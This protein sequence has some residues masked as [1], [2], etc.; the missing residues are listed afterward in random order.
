MNIE[1]TTELREVFEL[2]TLSDSKLLDL[3]YKVQKLID[4]CK[5]VNATC[6]LNFYQLHYRAIM[7]ELEYRSL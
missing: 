6:A 4:A 2:K 5:D 7:S 1:F 3:F